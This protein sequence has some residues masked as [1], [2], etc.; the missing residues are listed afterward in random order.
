MNAKPTRSHVE[1]EIQVDVKNFLRLN[2]LL[3]VETK[4]VKAREQQTLE[5]ERQQLPHDQE[6]FQM[7]VQQQMKK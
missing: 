1:E 5:R 6:Q 2:N 7:H 3:H 4:S